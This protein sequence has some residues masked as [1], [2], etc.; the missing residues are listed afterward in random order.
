MAHAPPTAPG[1][2]L[3]ASPT[4][5]R[6]LIGALAPFVVAT[7]VGLALLWPG[8][9]EPAAAPGVVPDDLVAAEVVG[10][11]RG[12]CGGVAPDGAEVACASWSVRL[13]EGPDQGRTVELPEQP[14]GPGSLDLDVGD[15]VVLSYV[16]D[17]EPDLRYA[18]ADRERRRP[19]LLLAGLFA[20]AV[21]VLGRFQGVRALFGIA[22]SLLV[23]TQFVLPAVL[24][25]SSPLAVALVGSSVIAFVGLYLSH[26]VSATT[27]TALLGTL[28]SLALVGVLA[29]IFVAATEMSG[30]ATEEVRIVQIGAEDL[31]VRGLLLGGMVIGALGVLD[32][33]TVTQVA[34]VAELRRADPS[35]PFSRLYRAAV[36]I[37]RD[38]IASTVNTLVLAYAGASLPL[39]LLFT[40]AQQGFSDVVNGE[41]VAV[42]VVRTL[43]GS[44]GLVA[45]VPITTA[46]AAVVAAGRGGPER[47]PR[48]RRPTRMR[49]RSEERF[50]RDGTDEGLGSGGR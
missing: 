49:S 20:A 9:P 37:G 42:E 41:T 27:T 26:G 36:R 12:P 29:S 40:Q 8:D 16:A 33:V 1:E 47:P 22:V 5:R 34:A 7:V 18:F 39:L 28:S 2:A 17:A 48:T 11:E 10:E 31:N 24:E 19:L 46:L 3:P 6:L 43:T 38:H 50:W 4:T 30:V 45:S 25:G 15:D 14:E 23:L 13:E 44:I 21:V 32:D 35:L